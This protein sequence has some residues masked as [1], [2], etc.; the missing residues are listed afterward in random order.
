MK[1]FIGVVAK[2]EESKEVQ[3]RIA[4]ENEHKV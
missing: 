3:I 4:L 1:R 2:N